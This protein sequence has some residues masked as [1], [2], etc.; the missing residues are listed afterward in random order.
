MSPLLAQSGLVIHPDECL[1]LGTKRTSRGFVAMSPGLGLTITREFLL[2]TDEV[3][4]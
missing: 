1:L 2:I 3:I 4:E